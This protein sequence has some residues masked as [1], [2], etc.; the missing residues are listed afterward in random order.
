MCFNFKNACKIMQSNVYVYFLY[1][2]YQLVE[3][4]KYFVSLTNWGVLVVFEK[5][6]MIFL[7][8]FSAKEAILESCLPHCGGT[9]WKPRNEFRIRYKK[10]NF[11]FCQFNYFFKIKMVF[12]ELE[13][14]CFC[15][16]WI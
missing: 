9:W 6:N 5:G 13:N 12:L 11:S 3:D 16:K 1:W 4:K 15:S 10:W 14:T 8:P 2:C 7:S